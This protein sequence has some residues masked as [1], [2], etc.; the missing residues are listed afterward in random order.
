MKTNEE[1]ERMRTSRV[2]T[3][4]RD[5]TPLLESVAFVVV[6]CGGVDL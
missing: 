2:Y 1:I 5:D 6:D 4:K 3:M